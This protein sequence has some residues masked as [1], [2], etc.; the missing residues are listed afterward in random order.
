MHRIWCGRAIGAPTRS[1]AKRL[2]CPA[3]TRSA[4]TGRTRSTP[5]PPKNASSKSATTS[6]RS[7]YRSSST[8]ATGFS[9]PGSP[10][11]IRYTEAAPG[12]VGAG[13]SAEP[14]PGGHRLTGYVGADGE[15]VAGEWMR[16]PLFLAELGA[17][18]RDD[19][20]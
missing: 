3:A 4:T 14:A 12:V 17:A 9:R 5:P 11:R 13:G 20:R 6:E 18:G 19:E 8:R 2:S 7:T 1:P 15:Q 10:M 16:T